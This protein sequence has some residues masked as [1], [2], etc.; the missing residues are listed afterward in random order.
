MVLGENFHQKG[1]NTSYILEYEYKN[2]GINNSR[3]NYIH[4]SDNL[5]NLI[6]DSFSIIFKKNLLIYFNKS[7]AYKHVVF[8]NTHPL[9]IVIANYIKKQKA[10][11]SI[12]YLHDP[13]KSDKSYYSKVKIISILLAELIQKLTAKYV[14]YVISPSE[15]SYELF[16][17]N[18]KFYRKNRFIAPLLI[19]D[20]IDQNHVS[21]KYFS[22]VGGVHKAT[23]HDDFIELVNY[24]GKKGINYNFLL[25]TS[26]NVLKY[27]K[28]LTREGKNK[29]TIINKKIIDDHEINNV[30]RES[31]AVF[32]F[33][34]EVT[35]SGVIPVSFMNGTP[36]I[37]REIQG[38]KQHIIH[39]YNGYLVPFH[40][41]PEDII[42]A[43]SLVINNYDKLSINAR[44][45]YEKIWAEN[46][47]ENYY[48]RLIKELKSL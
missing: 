48:G 35:Q 36:V 47:F 5:L 40:F 10:S 41:S 2:I 45:S 21:K 26:S 16:N 27:E 7:D 23:G 8:Y 32:R 34:K 42:N 39:G 31:Y 11:K 28:R 4:C 37:A 20:Q 43:M 15:Y 44:N 6:F 33:D 9:N 12:L 3:M 18:Y 22:I 1:F 25:I 38:L 24:V 17:K 19:P 29:L 46:N 13:F 30:I 14:D